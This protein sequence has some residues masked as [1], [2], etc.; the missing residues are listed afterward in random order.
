VT[1]RQPSRLLHGV[2]CRSP[3]GVRGTAGL[4][5]PSGSRILVM[6][7]IWY[8]PGYWHASAYGPYDPWDFHY[9]NWF[10]DVNGWNDFIEHLCYVTRFRVVMCL[11]SR[12]DSG[13][14]PPIVPVGEDCPPGIAIRTIPPYPSLADYT[15]MYEGVVGTFEPTHLLAISNASTLALE[16]YL[17]HPGY[18]E[19]K[20]WVLSE[21]CPIDTWQDQPYDVDM[22]WLFHVL[23]VINYGMLYYGWVLPPFP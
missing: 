1:V 22:R 6:F 14:C 2:P 23:N 17:I 15:S 5:Q 3:H 12:P 11:M 13:P 20:A 18:E 9:T 16:H 7:H 21:A 4:V 10:L 8:V 19:F